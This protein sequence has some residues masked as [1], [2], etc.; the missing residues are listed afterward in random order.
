MRLVDGLSQKE[1]LRFVVVFS[2]EWVDTK[3]RFRP[4]ALF[5]TLVF[6]MFNLESSSG[7]LTIQPTHVS[8]NTSR[9]R[10]VWG[11]GLSRHDTS[12]LCFGI[13]RDHPECGTS[14][15]T[16]SSQFAPRRSCIFSNNPPHEY[17]RWSS[18]LSRRSHVIRRQSSFSESAVN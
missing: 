1:H 15:T 11:T 9:C 16:I 18:R 10:G 17:T 12:D 7:S 14:L 4:K 3:F 13:L 5:S 6:S 2:S 8:I